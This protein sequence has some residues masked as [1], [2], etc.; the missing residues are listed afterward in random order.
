MGLGAGIGFP[1]GMPDPPWYRREVGL[2]LR[3]AASGRVVYE[4]QAFDE[5]PWL[6]PA[7]AWPAMLD[8]ALQG[9]PRPPQGL[10]RVDVPIPR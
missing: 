9:F 6:E 3:E 4:T 10:R 7:R 8:A 5:G 1:L 2:V